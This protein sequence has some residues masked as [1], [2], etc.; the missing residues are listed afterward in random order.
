MEILW[1]I[2]GIVGVIV[3]AFV[4]Y[5]VLRA[6]MRIIPEGQRLVIY[7]LGRFD[8]LAGPGMV[9]VIPG[10]E[11]VARTLEVRDHPLEVSVPGIFAFGVP[12]DLTISLW[13][14]YDLVRAAAGNK[15][16]LAQLVQLSEGERRRQVE[17]KMREALI[18]QISNLEKRMSLPATATPLDA[19]I[20]LAPGSP[21]YNELLAGLKRELEQTLPSVGVILNTAQSI[22]VTGRVIPDVIIDAIKRTQG[23]QIDS[24]WL[25]KYAT[26]LRRQFPDISSA[27]LDQML[28]SIEGVDVGN[29]Q[30]LRLE[31][32]DKTEAQ[33]ELEVPLDGSEEPG[34]IA[35]PKVKFQEATSRRQPG[36]SQSD[37]DSSQPAPRGLDK[38]DLT[39][40]KR[41]PRNNQDQRKSA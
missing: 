29:V 40:L 4:L 28:A 18:N 6:T 25:T 16:K 30:R 37:R 3:L 38:S 35:K 10:L 1:T 17:V 22:T 5:K 23:R 34:V 15:A 13:C 27:V 21:R 41:V 9:I 39:V 19:V 7:R 32:D 24:Q 36:P 31:Q 33:V 20:A 8:R 26:E 12:N 11:Q 2:V 14:S